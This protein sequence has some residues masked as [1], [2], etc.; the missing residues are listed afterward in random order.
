VIENR[1]YIGPYVGVDRRKGVRTWP[2]L[3]GPEP[4]DI[5]PGWALP[6]SDEPLPRLVE[7]GPLVDPVMEVSGDAA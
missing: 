1:D 5:L 6:I 3:G 2:S 7:P 4:E